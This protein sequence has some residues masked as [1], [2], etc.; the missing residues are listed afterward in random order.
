M[1]IAGFTIDDFF[2]EYQDLSRAYLFMIMVTN[3]AGSSPE[4]TKYLVQSS[5]M[6]PTTITPIDIN[7]QGT[8]FPVGS[9]QEFADW[10]VTFRLDNPGQI[11]RDFNEWMRRVHDPVTNIHGSPRDYMHDQEVWKLNPQ[12]N[13]TD[14]IKLVNAWP[15][16]V[17]ELSL[18]YG[19]K[20][21]HTFDVTFRYLYHVPA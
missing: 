10:T 11:R 19:T 6:P 18:D 8:V 16:T 13:I 20:E 14:R 21:I 4:K 7:W 17:G 12:G 15:T 3:P 9:T 1:A 2:A 5:S